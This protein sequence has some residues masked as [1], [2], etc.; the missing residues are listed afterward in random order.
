MWRKP[1]P[2][3]QAAL[4]RPWRVWASVA[5][6]VFVAVA[7]LLGF[8][9]VPAS[10]ASG[11]GTF[12]VICRALGLPGYQSSEAPLETASQATQSVGWTA[13]VRASLAN[14]DIQSGA[15]LAAELCAGCHGE[16]GISLDPAYPNLAEQPAAVL[17][18][19][20]HDYAAGLRRSDIMEPIAQTLEETQIIDLASF[21]S[22]QRRTAGVGAAGAVSNAIV[23]L[24]T[25]G[26]PTRAIPPCAACHDAG[27]AGPIETPNLIRQG[28]DYL[29]QQLIAFGDGTRTNDLYG[30]MR[31][32]AA[33]LTEFEKLRLSNYYS[34]Q[35]AR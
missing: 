6:A 19:Q 26:D 22:S 28:Q 30:R 23:D 35:P 7:V 14:A 10:E 12:G 16:I 32:I 31:G 15:T 33:E 13:D 1:V 8:L 29:H 17:Y 2:A 24:V 34:G 27:S 11:Y 3:E 20:L 18:K 4:D 5:V 25:I 9:L 21:F